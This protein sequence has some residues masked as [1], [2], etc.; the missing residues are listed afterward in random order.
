MA[1][2][3]HSSLIFSICRIQSTFSLS[4]VCKKRHDMSSPS[5]TIG[6][7]GS[8][9]H[10]FWTFHFLI[11]LHCGEAAATPDCRSIPAVYDTFPRPALLVCKRIVV[12]LRCFAPLHLGTATP[13]C[14]SSS[15]RVSA[16]TALSYVSRVYF[17]N[18]FYASSL[19]T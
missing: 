5:T 9:P 16:G 8:L 1:L 15:C 18:F 11:A 14:L 10:C 12:V 7:M 3:L 13:L 17:F 19:C 2:G 4:L 6:E